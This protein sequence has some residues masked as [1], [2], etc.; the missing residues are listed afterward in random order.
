MKLFLRNSISCSS[1][2]TVDSCNRFLVKL[3]LTRVNEH[4]YNVTDKHSYKHK[5]Q[6]D[7]VRSRQGEVWGVGVELLPAQ[8]SANNFSLLPC[9]IDSRPAGR[10]LLTGFA[11]RIVSQLS[12]RRLFWRQLC[13]VCRRRACK[14][15]PR[16]RLSGMTWRQSPTDVDRC[17]CRRLMPRPR[18]TKLGLTQPPPLP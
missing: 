13:V 9:C 16:T 14:S 6:Q 15:G 17:H 4:R 10:R 18:S 11:F 5:P 2:L 12:I 8:H 1:M 7:L 3:Q